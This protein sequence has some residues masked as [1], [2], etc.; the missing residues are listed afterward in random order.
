MRKTTIFDLQ[1]DPVAAQV[2]NYLSNLRDD[3]NDRVHADCPFCGKKAKRGQNHFTIYTTNRNNLYAECFVCGQKATMWQ[4]AKLLGVDLEDEFTTYTY[5]R[6]PQVYAAQQHDATTTTIDDARTKQKDVACATTSWASN[7]EVVMMRHA[8]ELQHNGA[9][10]D[11][12]RGWGY[13]DSI[14]AESGIGYNSN[15][16]KLIDDIWIPAGILYPHRDLI[17][18]EIV[19]V[20][21]RLPYKTSGLHQPDALAKAM[22]LE[23][24]KSKYTSIKG[25]KGGLTN[26][27]YVYRHHENADII[28]FAEGEKDCDNIHRAVMENKLTFVKAVLNSKDKVSVSLRASG[29]IDAN[30]RVLIITDDD[31]AG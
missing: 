30:S 26:Y 3:Y 24:T 7:M 23:P 1:N 28:I 31:E 5:K 4:L 21:V 9:I 12:L 19:M 15:W 10:L 2:A 20:H 6:R 17:T 29:I 11:V 27:G 8:Q 13:T 25:S 22:R 14:I 16:Y 18:N